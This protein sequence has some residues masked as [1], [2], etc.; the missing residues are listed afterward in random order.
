MRRARPAVALPAFFWMLGHGLHFPQ[1]MAGAVAPFPQTAGAASSLIG[2]YQTCAG[3][4][5]AIVMGAL[6]DGSA[7][8]LGALMLG[9]SIAAFL[10]Y[11]P[12]YRR[13]LSD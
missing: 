6:H 9:L 1:T 12:F 11:A 7:L 13:V 2:F 8:P 4:I 3:A 10:A 5:A